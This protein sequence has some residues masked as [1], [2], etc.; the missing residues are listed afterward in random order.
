MCFFIT[1]CQRDS[2]FACNMFKPLC[3]EK[4]VNE[5]LFI[6]VLTKHENSCVGAFVDICVFVFVI[7]IYSLNLN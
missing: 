3:D 6:C 5:N 2:L 1:K 4:P 7:K